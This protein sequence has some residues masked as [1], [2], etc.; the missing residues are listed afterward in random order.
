MK[1]MPFLVADDNC[2]RCVPP[3]LT[4]AQQVIKPNEEAEGWDYLSPVVISG[5]LAVDPAGFSEATGLT[6][7][8]IFT[9]VM[10]VIRVECPSTGA[11]YIGSAPVAPN[12]GSTRLS[13]SIGAGN[14]A[15][16]LETHYEVVLAGGP[17]KSTT[18]RRA[19]APGSRLYTSGSSF[20]F[21][22]ESNDSLFPVEAFKFEGGDFPM[23]SAWLLKFRADDL[24]IPY[25]SAARL[26]IN[27]DHPAFEVMKHKP[28]AQSDAL[29]VHQVLLQMLVTV[30][31]ESTDPISDT[32]EENSSGAVLNDLCLQFLDSS[33][34]ST[35]DELRNDPGRAFARL[36]AGMQLSMGEER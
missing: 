24:S 19:T 23:G 17:R 9:D 3:S 31:V 26:F 25:L 27:T 13:V 6:E 15:G 35:V 34:R 30:A 8:E 4:T 12:G 1:L 16:D 20:K 21:H 29:L 33:L 32:Y 14:V 10:A 2:V 11:R 18:G 36:Q 7:N 22:L 5:E 28:S